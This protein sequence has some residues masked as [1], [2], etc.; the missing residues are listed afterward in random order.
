[1]KPTR[2]IAAAL[3]ALALAVFGLTACSDT[4]DCDAA[5]TTTVTVAPVG[6]V[7]GKGGGKS[8]K[9]K[10]KKSKVKVHGTDD[11]EDDD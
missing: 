7:D 2:R 6:F 1:M 9:S 11:C 3:T 10:S 4:E 5:G 8:G